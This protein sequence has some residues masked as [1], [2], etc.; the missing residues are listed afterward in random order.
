MKTKK[1]ILMIVCGCVLVLLF[2]NCSDFGV[3]DEALYQQSLYDYQT[4]LDNE[5]LPQLLRSTNL[6]T[7]GRLNQNRTVDSSL[8]ADQVSI[9]IA[10]DRAA[11]GNLIQV[12]SGAGSEEAII[13]IESG[14]IKAQRLNSVGTTYN[15][16][17]EAL[18]PNTGDKVVIAAAFGSKASDITLLVNGLVQKSTV[19][20]TGAPFDYSYTLKEIVTAPSQGQVHEFIVYGGDSLNKEGKLSGQ[21]LNVMARYLANANRISNVV[22]DPALVN[23]VTDGGGGS[24]ESPQFLAAKAIFDAKCTSCHQVGGTS[25]NLKNLTE[26]KAVANGWV[27]KGNP[28]NSSLY[29]WLQGSVGS[30]P[31][32]M[33]KGGSMS[34]QEV[35]TIADWINSIP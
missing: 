6:T 15:E 1:N 33:P 27:V 9:I 11:Q 17:R 20:Q 2:Q 21:E 5:L 26:S 10:V 7:W 16:Y 3:Q 24:T 32:T 22:F 23:E 29:Y 31:K 8:F 18:L 19:Q 34:A 4:D 13:S 12:R 30:G 14:K 35:Q 25:P 28:Q